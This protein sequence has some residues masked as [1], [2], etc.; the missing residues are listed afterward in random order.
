V[1][2]R[3]LVVEDSQTQAEALRHLLAD[4]GYEVEVAATGG[5]GLR[6]ARET[7]FDLIL[8]DILMPGMNGYELCR[9]I[10]ADTAAFGTPP[11]ALLTSLGDP[12]DIIRG[13]ECAADN[14]LIKHYNRPTRLLAR[15]RQILKNHEARRVQ[16]AGEGV[17]ITVLGE[18]VNINARREQILDF[19][20]STIE[21]LLE[22][23]RALQE[24]RHELQQT[25]AREKASRKA[26]EAAT[27]EREL[28]LATVSHDLRSPLNTILMST[29][30]LLDF[31]PGEIEPKAR[32]RIGVINRTATQMTR[33]I[34]DLLDVATLEAGHLVLERTWQDP[35]A[36]AHEGLEMLE[37]IAT[38]HGIRLET[39]IPDE[40][41]RIVADHKRVLQVIS[42]LIGNAIKFTPPGG[43]ISLGV[44]HE[45]NQLLF[46]VADSGPGI[47]QEELPRLFDRFWRGDH[48][49]SGAGLGL[50]IA[51]G[52]IE[53]HGGRIWAESEPG[54]GATFHFSLPLVDAP[55]P[56]LVIHKPLR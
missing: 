10:K 12:I 16:S 7:R 13:L 2:K 23:N 30:L 42:N 26:A 6:R 47:R 50:S 31:H 8:S 52:A 49:A 15:I 21:E 36:L 55:H 1:S 56:V 22:V 9:Q 4:H 53:A 5:E 24:K 3:I 43:R 34:E 54:Q 41:P 48:A 39:E 44:R 35:A 46:S 37:P 38:D 45:G 32:D 40:L 28:V 18:Q 14:Y 17:E 51:R 19:F 20:L 11:V 25:L 29:S 33:L 27:A